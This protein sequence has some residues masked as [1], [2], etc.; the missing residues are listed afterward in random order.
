MSGQSAFAVGPDDNVNGL[1]SG[2]GMPILRFGSAVWR[3]LVGADR[4]S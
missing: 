1:L 2:K 4:E 3:A